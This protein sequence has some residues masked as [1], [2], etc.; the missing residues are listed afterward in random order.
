MQYNQAANITL[1]NKPTV[2]KPSPRGDGH[3]VIEV[4]PRDAAGQ[5]L[6]TPTNPGQVTLNGSFATVKSAPVVG[7]KTVTTTAASIF[8]G[9]AALPDRYAMTVYND[10]S[11]TI[12]W[13]PSG[14]T[15]S[16]GMPILPGDSV[17]F[18]F[19]QSVVTA[20]YMIAAASAA[21]RVM[22]VA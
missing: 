15:T 11:Y 13:G 4:E 22:E 5:M 2:A 16:T 21:I 6:F 7:A 3:D 9:S 10:S 17:T 18:E 19:S 1:D 8:A 20:I 14:V 12:Y